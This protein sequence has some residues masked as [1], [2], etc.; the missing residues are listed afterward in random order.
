M[1]DGSGTDGTIRT[2]AVSMDEIWVR[3]GQSASWF[4]GGGGS[5][6]ATLPVRGEPRRRRVPLHQRPRAQGRGDDARHALPLRR[7]DAHWV[8]HE[9][10]VDTRESRNA[11]A[12][13]EL[14]KTMRASIYVLGPLLARYGGGAC[15]SRRLRLGARPVDL[16]IAG[17]Q[18][19]RCRVSI[20]HG[21]IEAEADT[22]R[23]II[24]SSTS[25]A[26]APPRTS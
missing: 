4:R 6:N 11:E 20:D 23:A 26:W 13:Y 7:G 19:A 2:A 1:E 9:I 3:G 21:Y 10:E 22:P 8:L 25:W 12:P 17:M 14:V 5:K 24:I 18:K 16:H 15:P